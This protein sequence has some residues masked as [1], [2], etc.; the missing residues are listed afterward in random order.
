MKANREK[1]VI[2]A[3]LLAISIGY[4]YMTAHLPTRNLPN[5]L[6]LDFMPWVYDILL[7]ILSLLLIGS[8]IWG[9][10]G[11]AGAKQLGGREIGGTFILFAIF[12]AYIYLIDAVG[13]L[14]VTPFVVF[15]MMLLGGAR[16]Y[17]KMGVIS[18]VVT[19]T[20]YVL[21]RYVFVVSITGIA[22]T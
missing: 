15:A 17:V 13:F 11:G 7:A 14:I 22:F 20:I 4:G 8:G 1:I 19:V 12:V 3:V 21:F 6:G 18:V 9:S 16:Q 5:T 2:G 10:T